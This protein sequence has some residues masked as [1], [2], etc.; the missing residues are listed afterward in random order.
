MPKTGGGGR[1]Y[2][3]CVPLIEHLLPV[4][5]VDEEIKLFSPLIKLC[6]KIPILQD[7]SVGVEGGEGEERKEAS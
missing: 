2:H 1:K 4:N 3:T 6:E 7:L 5:N